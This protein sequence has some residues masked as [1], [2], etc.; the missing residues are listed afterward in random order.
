MSHLLTLEDRMGYHFRERSLLE[1][2]LTHSS[3][4]NEQKIRR[5]E[6][7]ERLE[8]LGDAVLEIISSAYLYRQCPQSPEGDLSRMRAALVCEPALARCALALDLS[9]YIR[10][11][12][13]EEQ[14][15][16][17]FRDSIVAD[18]MEA[19]IGA[20]YLD[21][22]SAEEPEKF[23]RR[24]ILRD[25]QEAILHSDA[26]TMLQEK[27]QSLGLQ[28]HYELL[29]ESGPDHDKVYR[30]GVFL[31]D[32]LLAEVEGRSKKT[33]GQEAA[34]AAL[35]RGNREPGLFTCI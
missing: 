14:S 22:G 9:A 29:S 25:P 18:V 27:V 12:R 34:Y 11:G 6:D 2:A 13:G 30:I 33:A 19:I 5:T 4:A 10:V 26:K 24:F 35:A 1:C 17:R 8:S 28:V 32:R 3:Y 15:G 7:Y 20:M 31:Q 16:G 21:S 23:I